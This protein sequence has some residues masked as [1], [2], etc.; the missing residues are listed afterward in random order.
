MRLD[1]LLAHSGFGTRKDVKKLIKDGLVTVNDTQVQ[2]PGL[3]VNSA[4]DDIRVSGEP[5]Y[6]QEF[7]YFMMNKPQDVISATEDDFHHTVID[8]LEPQDLIQE[9]FPVG[10]LDID[11]EGL[12][13]LTNDGK[14]SHKL[15][16][17][18]RE[19][20]KEYLAVID[21][22]MDEEDV[23][24]FSKGLTLDDGYKT[25]PAELEILEINQEIEESKVSITVTEGKFH[26]VKRMVQARGHEVTY[27]KRNRMGNL[28]LDNSLEPGEYRPLTE[29]EIEILEHS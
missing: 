19:V 17:P 21:G 2:K 3:H 16:S 7:F 14:L 5:V 28:L 18:N 23:A 11:T 4:E 26:Q 13:I 1:K 6:Y 9:P 12:L 15:T 22:V 10:R 24:A 20:E 27:L 29:K 25:K 8:L